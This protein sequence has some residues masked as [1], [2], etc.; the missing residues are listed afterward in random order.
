MAEE[1]VVQN[2]IQNLEKT[3]DEQLEALGDLDKIREARIKAIKKKANDEAEWRANG[4]GE[5]SEIENESAFF[6]A[7]KKSDK[8]VC[9]FYLKTTERCKILDKH[10]KI[11]APQ[12]L[13]TKFVKLDAEKAPFLTERMMIKVIP[14]IVCIVGSTLVDRI[15]GFT[16]LGNCDDFT[17]KDLKTRLS[18]HGAVDYDPETSPTL[19]RKMKIELEQKRQNLRDC[20]GQESDDDDDENDY[21]N[22]SSE[23][24]NTT[25]DGSTLSSARDRMLEEMMAELDT[26]S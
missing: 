25:T 22:R 26:T 11:L 1:Q 19:R 15:V 12:M 4:H 21:T 23:E 17:T 5:Y 3:V 2:V 10:F 6:A 7:S 13:G 24:K 20:N 16:D 9:H 14:C 8:L 18:L